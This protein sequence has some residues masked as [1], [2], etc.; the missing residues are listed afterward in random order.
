MS[1]RKGIWLPVVLAACGL[2]WEG[3][4]ASAQVQVTEAL[5]FGPKDRLKHEEVVWAQIKVAF[6]RT[7]EIVV[8][9]VRLK[10]K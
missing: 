8:K 4:M 9:N 1:G 2:A 7:A 10:D 3:P 6:V 5:R